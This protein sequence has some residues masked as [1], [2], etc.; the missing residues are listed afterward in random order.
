MPTAAENWRSCTPDR[1]IAPRT[2]STAASSPANPEGHR[3]GH[4]P[5]PPRPTSRTP[6]RW[7]AAS[8][9]TP[10]HRYGR[11]PGQA[12]MQYD[13]PRATLT[14]KEAT[15]A[16]HGGAERHALVP[17]PWTAAWLAVPSP[18]RLATE[19]SADADA[20]M[21]GRGNR[22][23]RGLRRGNRRNSRGRHGQPDVRRARRLPAGNLLP[24]VACGVASD[25]RTTDRSDKIKNYF[26]TASGASGPVWVRRPTEQAD[27]AGPPTWRR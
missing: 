13:P 25:R 10:R 1:R 27:R 3:P 2:P 18:R 21:A 4:C 14:L 17:V 26:R 11:R 9:S 16:L 19:A 5:S 23:D 20:A 24:Q 12:A 8:C 7:C 6:S 22:V 15:P